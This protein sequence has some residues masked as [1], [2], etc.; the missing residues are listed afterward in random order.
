[1]SVV[2]I[3]KKNYKI[4]DVHISI[5]YSRFTTQGSEEMG[6]L[7]FGGIPVAILHSFHSM[8]TIVL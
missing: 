5:Y 2:E 8:K 1:M 3:W 7:W 4:I 6:V